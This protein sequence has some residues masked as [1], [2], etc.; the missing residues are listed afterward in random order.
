MF[1]HIC[2]HKFVIFRVLEIFYWCIFNE[3]SIIND[4]IFSA[5]NYFPF[6]T[7]ICEDWCE[8]SGKVSYYYYLSVFREQIFTNATKHN[9][10]QILTSTLSCSI[11]TF[12]VEEWCFRLPP[13]HTTKY[14]INVSKDNTLV[15]CFFFH[16]FKWIWINHVH[17]GLHWFS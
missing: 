4:R 9:K 8:T 5:K 10:Q 12:F 16:G 15:F 1:I 7:C 14:N 2:T 11:F 6:F 13:R 17:S 3:F